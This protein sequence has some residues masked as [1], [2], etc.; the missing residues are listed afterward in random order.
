MKFVI[1]GYYGFNNSGD[2]AL[3]LAILN[4]IKN[5]YEYAEIVVLSKK[6]AETRKIYQVKSVNRY[7]IFLMLK[8]IFKCDCLISGGGSLIQDATS[9]KSL[10]YYLSVIK[11]A[12]IFRKKI[13]LYANGIGPLNSFKNIEKTKN[14]LN[15]VDLITLRDNA[16]ALE[17]EH[18]GVTIP[19]IEVTADPAFLLNADDNGKKILD[20]YNVPE[21]KRYMCVSVRE[22][23]DNPENFVEIMAEFCDY[24]YEKYNFYTVFLPMQ[25][26]VDF[27]ISSKIKN[28]MKNR[29]TVIGTKFPIESVLSIMSK[30]DICVGMRLHSLIYSVNCF[31][32][33][34]GLM[35]DPKIKG[36][37]DYIENKYIEIATLDIESLKNIFDDT[38]KN[39]DATA[40]Q[41]KYTVRSLRKK[42][43]NNIELLD[44]LLGGNQ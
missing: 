24:A 22:W 26:C 12:Q 14:I 29:S 30:A 41:I 37:M 7:N 36:F 3:L 35:Y 15:D 28:A 9:T 19:K 5:K 25:H 33:T 44:E 10:L 40:S 17:L 21:D 32:P 43:E 11:I 13:M 38:I 4:S 6:P 42:A 27:E 2:D 8:H 18:I 20:S 34:I 31:V 39:Y 1:S 23:K 16:S